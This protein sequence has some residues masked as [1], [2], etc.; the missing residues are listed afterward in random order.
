METS[1]PDQ[2][3]VGSC[4]SGGMFPILDCIYY[5]AHVQMGASRIS[6]YQLH[7]LPGSVPGSVSR[8]N[9]TTTRV[10]ERDRVCYYPLPTPFTGSSG[11]YGSAGILVE[12]LE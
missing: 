2:E 3:E 4:S 1:I 12:D 8:G 11:M 6:T 5:L 9:Y 10:F 7:L